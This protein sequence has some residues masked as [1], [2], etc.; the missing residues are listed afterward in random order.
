MREIRC[1]R[2]WDDVLGEMLYSRVEQFDDSLMFRFEKHFETENPVY[3]WPTGLL[4][5]NGKEIYGGDIIKQR[6]SD[7]A[8]YC[9]NVKFEDVAMIVEWYNG[10]A[11]RT[12]KSLELN[13]KAAE[14]MSWFNEA[15]KFVA[16]PIVRTKFTIHS[17]SSFHNCEVI[18]NIYENPELLK[19]S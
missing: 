2:A 5:K 9:K 17:W 11:H 6:R 15:P 16:R 13:P 19:D 12:E 18:G 14:N 7:K 10:L 1:P 8:D 3:M 4:D